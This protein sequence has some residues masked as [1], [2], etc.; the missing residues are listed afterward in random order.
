MSDRP[1]EHLDIS[2]G[3][4]ELVAILLFWGFIG[5]LSAAGR[6]IDPRLP[7]RPEVAAALA[8]V[9]LAEY[10]LWALLSIPIVWLA[11]RFSLEGGR[12]L[13][14]LVLFVL[15]G[16]VLAVCVD[17]AITNLRQ[18]LL[19]DRPR[20]RAFP[21]DGSFGRRL[22]R[23]RPISSLGFLDDLMVY[24][25][26]FGGGVARDYFLRY[27]ARQH[28]A[29]RLESQAALLQA[30][31]AEARLAVLRT[32][33]D[34]HFLFNTL[35]AVSALV[36]RDPR[37]VRRM[38]ARLSDLLR[39][40]LESAPRQEVPLEEELELLRRYL[41][42]ME[43]RFQGRLAVEIDVPAALRS[44]YVPHLML[45]PLVENALK[46][47]VA[48]LE[49]MGRVAVRGRR[50]GELLVLSVEDNGAGPS[51]ERRQ[52]VGLRNTIARLE[53]L[54]GEVATFTLARASAGGALAEVRLPFR[55]T[56]VTEAIA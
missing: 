27:R 21:G 12:R 42:I 52:G 36:E 54:Y 8:R 41:D 1:R 9:T 3:S 40:T 43:I 25:A 19:P 13:E 15:A 51:P 28:E 47:G 38:I 24:F 14:R 35:N 23:P 30:Q 55:T 6:M 33:L 56:P 5:L 39:N 44:A 26:V 2:L 29:V 16:V 18:E 17:W 53:Q 50:E 34:P 7:T 32:Q 20:R 45:Q 11:A 31:L 22:L 46:H 10:A 49:E 37:G 4:R 48:D